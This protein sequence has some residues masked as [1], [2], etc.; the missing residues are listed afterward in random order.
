[1]IY[2]VKLTIDGE[3]KDLVFELTRASLVK[4]EERGV[5]IFAMTQQP[6]KSITG[7][8]Y[9][10]MQ[11][12]HQISWESAQTYSDEILKQY[13]FEDLMMFMAEA[14][15]SVFTSED[16]EQKI[17]PKPLSRKAK[18]ESLNQAKSKKTNTSTAKKD[19]A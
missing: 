10:A 14:V 18:I 19:K 3:E 8:V 17:Y 7:F 1:M 9:A 13:N 16:S 2:D 5:N 12:H 6:L 11:K 4:A 15:D